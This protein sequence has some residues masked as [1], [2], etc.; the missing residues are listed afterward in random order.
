MVTTEQTRNRFLDRVYDAARDPR[1]WPAALATL[2][3]LL[4]NASV[5]L[6]LQCSASDQFRIL[7]IARH[8]PRDV[9]KFGHEFGSFR[10]NPFARKIVTSP[11]GRAV[12]RRSFMTE[13]AYLQTHLYRRIYQPRALFH[14]MEIAVE[15]S[16]SSVAVLNIARPRAVQD[17]DP[18][19]LER[20]VPILPHLRRALEFRRQFSSYEAEKTTRVEAL[21][22]LAMA[23]F[24]VTARGKPLWL[25]RA[26]KQIIEKNEGL[27]VDPVGLCTETSKQT[28]QLRQMIHHAAYGRGGNACRRSRVMPLNRASVPSPLLLL[29]VP[30][31]SSEIAT[32]TG[33][34]S[35]D[36]DPVVLILVSDPACQAEVPVSTL[37]T[38]FGL[39]RAE[40]R[41]A[42]ALAAGRSLGDAAVDFGIKKGTA[43]VE[44]SRIY[45]K[46]DTHRQAELVKLLL[47]TPCAPDL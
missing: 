45:S 13:K 9:V 5:V 34:P 1:R 29:A 32:T 24:A 7:G 14:A 39:T 47:T 46:T 18:P 2:G 17:F 23:V 22:C 43:R 12:L 6:R 27:S 41:L 31:E 28:L 10:S 19:E 3:D 20:L 44:L 15:R 25:N 4:G 37:M 21:N 26:A 30:T 8:S 11:L 16:G 35:T 33:L 38:L 36:H 40:A 42:K